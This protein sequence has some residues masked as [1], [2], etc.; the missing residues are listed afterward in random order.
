MLPPPADLERVHTTLIA[1]VSMFGVP[2]PKSIWVCPKVV[3]LAPVPVVTGMLEFDRSAA[4]ATQV[5]LAVL[6]L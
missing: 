4:Y 3:V 1:Y 2:T 5:L 6:E